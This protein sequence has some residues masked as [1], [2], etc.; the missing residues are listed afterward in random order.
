MN[1]L[2]SSPLDILYR[3]LNF[4]LSH[5]CLSTSPRPVKEKEKTQNIFFQFGFSPIYPNKGQ[6][7][8]SLGI[9]SCVY[10]LPSDYLLHESSLYELSQRQ[11][12]EQREE[13]NKIIFVFVPSVFLSPPAHRR[14][15]YWERITPS[16]AKHPAKNWNI[17]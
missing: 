13:D 14:R 1:D 16:Q 2:I 8:I 6:I 17:R 15:T 5:L 11:I 3:I 4:L 12:E 9:I 7:L 10:Y